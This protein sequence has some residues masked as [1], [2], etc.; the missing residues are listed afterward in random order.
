MI[1]GVYRTQESIN[2]IEVKISAQN[3]VRLTEVYTYVDKTGLMYVLLHRE[4]GRLLCFTDTLIHL[5]A[6][7]DFCSWNSTKWFFKIN[8]YAELCLW[9]YL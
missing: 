9:M 1:W 6:L 3:Q 2:K 5:P 4:R 7:Q 8:D